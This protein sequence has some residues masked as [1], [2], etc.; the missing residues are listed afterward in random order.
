MHDT[1]LIEKIYEAI[2]ELCRINSII[3]VIALDIEVDEGSHIDAALLREHLTDRD[4]SLFGDWTDVHVIY[5]HFEKLTAVI[6]NIDG[7]SDS[8]A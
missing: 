3:K 1:H 8:T 7:V 2:S 5:R 6:T 4:G